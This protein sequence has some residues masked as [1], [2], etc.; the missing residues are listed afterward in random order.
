MQFSVPYCHNPELVD[1][2]Q[3]GTAVPEDQILSFLNGRRAAGSR[4]RDRRGT[5]NP[6]EPYP[7]LETLKD[8]G[9]LI[10]V[11]TNGSKPDYWKH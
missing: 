11:D 7:F 4:Y 8:M 2:A 10:K 6:E 3:Y 1:P 9:Y 5:D